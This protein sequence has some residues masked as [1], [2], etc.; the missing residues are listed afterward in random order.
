MNTVFHHSLYWKKE[1]NGNIE[2]VEDDR[3][4]TL[5]LNVHQMKSAAIKTV[6]I[7]HIIHGG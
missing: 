5:V 7:R 4:I 6:G 3:S 1:D 2:R